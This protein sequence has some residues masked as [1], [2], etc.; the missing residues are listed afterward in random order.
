[1]L[2][3][4][5][6]VVCQVLADLLACMV[7]T[8]TLNE[9]HFQKTARD[10]CAVKRDASNKAFPHDAAWSCLDQRE[11]QTAPSTCSYISTLPDHR[12]ANRLHALA[13]APG[14][15]P[16]AK[17]SSESRMTPLHHSGSRLERPRPRA[18][19]LAKVHTC[20]QGIIHPLWGRFS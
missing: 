4:R 10:I 17:V 16:W 13:I 3:V 8:G 15:L 18:D 11:F 2:Q 19:S 20:A 7:S 9:A 5:A 1:M 12:G 14:A 6:C